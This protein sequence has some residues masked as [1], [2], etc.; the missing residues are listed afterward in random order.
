MKESRREKTIFEIA[1][2]LA[3]L[4]DEQAIEFEKLLDK[5]I[6]EKKSKS[7]T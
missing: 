2:L 3:S 1:R 5:Y 4:T 7:Q 6:T